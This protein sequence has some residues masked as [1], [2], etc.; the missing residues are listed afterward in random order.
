M[1]E[2]DPGVSLESVLCTEQL[3]RRPSRVPDY[4]AENHALRMLALELTHAPESVLQSLVGAALHLCA[5]HSSGIS[6]LED[7]PPGHLS[8]HGDHFRWHAVAGRWAPLIWSTTTPRELSPCGTVLDRNATLLFTH[9]PRYFSQFADVQPALV[10]ALLAPFHVDGHAVGTVWVVAHDESRQFDAEDQRLLEGLAAFAATAYQVRLALAAQLQVHRDAQAEMG[11]RRRNEEALLKADRR[12]SEFLA[13]LAHEL[14]NPLA[15]IWNAIQILGQSAGDDTR[16]A[17]VVEMMHRQ[18][19]HLRRLVDDLLDVSR[20]SRDRIVLQKRPVELAAVV[21]QAVESIR[22][23]CESLEHQLSVELPRQ[24]IHMEADAA[25]LTQVVGNLLSNACKFADPG[26]L[27]RLTVEPEGQQAVIRVVDTGIGLLPEQCPRIFEMFTQLDASLERSRDG[28]GIGL[29][30]VKELVEKH[31]GTVEARSAGLGQGSEFIVRLP[32]LMEP[33][34]G[35]PRLPSGEKRGTTVRRRILVVDDHQDSAATLAMLLKMSGH[36]VHT[37][38]DGVEA[39]EAAAKCQPHAVLLDIGLPRLNGYEAARRIREQRGGRGP[40]LVA[41]TGWGQAEDR[42]RSREAGFD[43]HLVKP[44]DH[45]EL[46]TL[47]DELLP[48]GR[49]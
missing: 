6:L 9:A 45:L 18:V 36:E 35:A 33:S 5:A 1:S 17:P 7:G 40:A 15:P 14:R 43:A 16:V 47:L 25:R 44:V 48:A 34:R 38:S 24:P 26:G 4:R 46:M 11:Q 2:A 19:L 29:T 12:K 27:I 13:L 31:G 10:E 42:R 49:S 21:R 3:A 8:P 30:L 23:L 28:L 32:V 20:I 22:P 37:A 41:L 39:I